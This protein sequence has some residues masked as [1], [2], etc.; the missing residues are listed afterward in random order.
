MVKT[1]LNRELII[2]TSW[3]YKR[4]NDRIS[5]VILPSIS[6]SVSDSV[7]GV[8]RFC[9]L[10]VS[11]ALRFYELTRTERSGNDGLFEQR[12]MGCVS[13]GAFTERPC[14]MVNKGADEE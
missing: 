3:G 13:H 1:L 12:V 14:A 10:T 11:G 7:C 2:Y 6:G 8:V 4:G 5:V 9:E